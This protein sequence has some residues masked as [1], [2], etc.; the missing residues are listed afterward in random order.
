MIYDDFDF[1]ACLIWT[2]ISLVIVYGIVQI[3]KFLSKK[4]ERQSEQWRI[5]QQV[6]LINSPKRNSH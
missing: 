3:G 5:S 2:V 6:S 1:R 4:S